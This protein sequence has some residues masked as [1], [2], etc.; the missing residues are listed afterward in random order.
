MQIDFHVKLKHM[1][2]AFFRKNILNLNSFLSS[3]HVSLMD[4]PRHRPIQYKIFRD[5]IKN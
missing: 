1:H 4:I 5:S 3:H 2:P